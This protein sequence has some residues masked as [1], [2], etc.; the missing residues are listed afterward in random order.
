[1]G[2][3]GRRGAAAPFSAS[4]SSLVFSA[5]A[6]SPRPAIVTVSS[7]SLA[8]TVFAVDLIGLDQLLQALQVAQHGPGAGDPELAAGFLPALVPEACSAAAGLAG[9]RGGPGE[10]TSPFVT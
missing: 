4:L 6:P 2:G 9:C 1:V 8:T 5:L 3:E 10:R 7:P